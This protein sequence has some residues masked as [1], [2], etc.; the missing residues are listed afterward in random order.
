MS[1]EKVPKLPM[2]ENEPPYIVF[3]HGRQLGLF[4]AEQ[5]ITKWFEENYS[6]EEEKGNLSVPKELEGFV[7]PFTKSTIS[8]KII[9][10]ELLKELLTTLNLKSKSVQNKKADA[11]C[12]CGKKLNQETYKCECGEEYE[13]SENVQKGNN[14]HQ[15]RENHSVNPVGNVSECASMNHSDD[16]LNLKSKNNSHNPEEIYTRAGVGKEMKPVVEP[17]RDEE[18]SGVGGRIPTLTSPVTLSLNLKTT[19]NKE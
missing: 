7:K 15:K 10:P 13:Q 17:P 1:E 8:Y 14:I 19:E 2:R 6:S 9:S 12:T 5:I 11:Y 18:L 3:E 16:S 4:E